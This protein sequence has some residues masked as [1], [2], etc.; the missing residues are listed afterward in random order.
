MIRT[1]KPALAIKGV[2]NGLTYEN[3]CLKISIERIYYYNNVSILFTS[4]KLH[5]GQMT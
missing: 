5:A 2:T 4:V 3:S 1:Q